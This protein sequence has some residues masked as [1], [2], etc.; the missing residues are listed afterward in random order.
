[1]LAERSKGV[2]TC[3]SERRSCFALYIK[4]GELQ[5]KA[6]EYDP[7]DSWNLRR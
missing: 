1:M 4:G 2:C 5:T 6:H 7:V 3:R